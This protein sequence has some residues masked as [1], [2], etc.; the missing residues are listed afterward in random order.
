MTWLFLTKRCEKMRLERS[1]GHAEE[2]VQ[3]GQIVTLLHHFEVL[4]A[5]GKAA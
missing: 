4:V 3:C 5:Q 1:L 2:E